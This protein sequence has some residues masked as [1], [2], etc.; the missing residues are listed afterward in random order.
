M[1]SGVNKPPMEGVM[2]PG[3]APEDGRS[4]SRL[5]RRSRL[6]LGLAAAASAAFFL[7]GAFFTST[8]LSELLSSELSELSE[9]EPEDSSAFLEVVLSGGFLVTASPRSNKR[10]VV[11]LLAAAAF[12]LC[13]LVLSGSLSSSLL[14]PDSDS[15]PLLLPLK[16]L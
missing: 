14:E 6:D 7:G 1:A 9:L 5:N 13:F 16:N 4:S 8:S 11:A 15:L 2:T 3:T 10:P 12:G